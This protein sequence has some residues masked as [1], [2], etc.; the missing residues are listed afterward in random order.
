MDVIKREEAKRVGSGGRHFIPTS[1][2]LGLR[3]HQ[4]EL[5]ELGE[6]LS[7]AREKRTHGCY[8]ERRGTRGGTTALANAFERFWTLNGGEKARLAI[9]DVRGAP[10]PAADCGDFARRRRHAR[11]RVYTDTPV[12]AIGMGARVAAQHL[13]FR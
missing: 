5:R 12:H 6:W 10:A 7:E 3:V 4:V 11:W 8:K 9:R 1:D 13:Q 2:E